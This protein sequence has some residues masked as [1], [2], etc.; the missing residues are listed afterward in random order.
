MEKSKKER[1]DKINWFLDFAQMD[2]TTLSPGDRVKLCYEAES[3][4]VNYGLTKEEEEFHPYPRTKYLKDFLHEIDVP[5]LHEIEEYFQVLKENQA[6]LKGYIFEYINAITIEKKSYLNPG[7]PTWLVITAKQG[8]ISLSYLPDVLDLQGVAINRFVKLLDGVPVEGFRKCL[9][10]KKIFFYPHRRKKEF[11]SVQC[12]WKFF[13]RQ[14]RESN[15]EAYRK[16]QREVMGKR[17]EK[18]IR[19]KHPKAARTATIG[20]GDC[21]SAAYY[22]SD[23]HGRF[24]YR[25]NNRQNHQ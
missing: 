1:T 19:E 14:R 4:M 10:C 17:Y 12:G 5:T 9:E 18:K 21:N 20:S 6:D 11:C 24:T 15:P 13:A 3:N 8:N 23:H 16:Y 7:I 22:N 25:Q 2:L